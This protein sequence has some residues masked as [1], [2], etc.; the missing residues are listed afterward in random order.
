M[1][2]ESHAMASRT[3]RRRA[4]AAIKALGEVARN[5]GLAG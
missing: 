2:E 1:V 3:V 5:G 4:S